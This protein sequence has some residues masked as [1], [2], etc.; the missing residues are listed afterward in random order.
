MT[1][2]QIQNLSPDASNFKRGKALAKTPKWQLLAKKEK[3]VWG[4]CKGSGSNPYKVQ[5]DLE[6]PAYKCSCPSRKFPCKHAIGIMLLYAQ[7]TSDFTEKKEADVWVQEWL[8]KRKKTTAKKKDPKEYTD[9]ELVKKQKN[10]EKSIAKRQREMESGIAELKEWLTDT[11]QLGIAELQSFPASYFDE[12]G[13]RLHDNKLP[14]LGNAVKEL[15]GQLQAKNWQKQS[16]ETLAWLYTIAN[17]FQQMDKLSPALQADIKSVIGVNMKKDEVIEMGEIIADDWLVL[18]RKQETSLTDS[19]LRFQR[20]WLK[21]ANTHQFALLLDFSFRNA[22]FE[23]NLRTAGIFT[24]EI[25]YYPGFPLRAVIKSKKTFEGNL[26][27]LAV[28]G[29]FNEYLSQYAEALVHNPF[30]YRY[31]F[32]VENIYFDKKGKL[33]DQNKVNIPIENTKTLYKLLALSGG[34]PITLFGEWSGKSLLPM[35]V[36]T[37]GRVF[38]L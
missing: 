21:G 10:K 15:Y 7:N 27:E 17:G 26:G 8:D 5:V 9:E 1:E 13:R 34:L 37:D 19:Q 28:H 16:M 20:T 36:L 38:A 11:M 30:L 22:P 2:E 6:E 18:G 14:S 24:G 35:S 25:A 23:N 31:P 32:I 12:K 4:L 3:I 33:Y 29:D